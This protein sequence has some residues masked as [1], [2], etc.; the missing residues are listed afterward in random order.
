MHDPKPVLLVEDDDLDALIVKRS[1]NRL[2]ITNE[3]IRAI[4][5]TIG[6][7]LSVDTGDPRNKP[8]LWF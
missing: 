3:L 7:G 5:C 2:G 6:S 1:M 8:W 4:A